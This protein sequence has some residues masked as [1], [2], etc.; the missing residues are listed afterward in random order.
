M[1]V[2]SFILAMILARRQDKQDVEKVKSLSLHHRDCYCCH[3]Y[4]SYDLGKEIGYTGCRKSKI[5]VFTSQI[6]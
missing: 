5:I 1:I 4:I 6:L 3:L 2:V